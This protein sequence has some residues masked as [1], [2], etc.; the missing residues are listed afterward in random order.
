MWIYFE[1]WMKYVLISVFLE[2]M[3]CYVWY[4]RLS[5]WNIGE[6]YGNNGVEL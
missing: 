5:D 2:S 4:R 1:V 6:I 3:Y